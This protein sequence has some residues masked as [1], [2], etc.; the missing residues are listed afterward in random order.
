MPAHHYESPGGVVRTLRPAV[1]S[2][3]LRDELL[4]LLADLGP[5]L[6]QISRAADGAPE[7]AARPLSAARRRIERT[8]SRLP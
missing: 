8:L 1:G 2:D 4:D 6:L 5:L 3:A 7:V